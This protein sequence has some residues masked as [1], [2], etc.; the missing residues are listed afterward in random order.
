MGNGMW[1][2]L[3]KMYLICSVITDIY[4][5]DFVKGNFLTSCVTSLLTNFA[6]HIHGVSKILSILNRKPAVFSSKNTT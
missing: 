3:L 6:D 5:S 2:E 1:F 4:I